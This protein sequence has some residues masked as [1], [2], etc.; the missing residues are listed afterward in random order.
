MLHT[1]ARQLVLRPLVLVVV[2]ALA[3]LPAAAGDWV[4]E[5]ENGSQLVSRYQPREST[6]DPGVV[7]LMTADGNTIGLS[8]S[9]IVS[10][11]SDIESRGF[12]T[13]IDSKTVALGWAPN[14]LPDPEAQPDSTL[15]PEMQL[16]QQ[17]VAQQNQ[18]QQNVNVDQFVDPGLA[19][20]GLP[21]FGAPTGGLPGDTGEPAPGGLGPPGVVGAPPSFGLPVPQ[22]GSLPSQGTSVPLQSGVVPGQGGSV[23]AQPAPVISP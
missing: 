22:T 13:V 5:L 15:S 9:D 12:G 17:M 3:A 10:V 2:F 21:V 6:W 1:P 23:P 7:L 20:G 8:R 11:R 19:G 14:D 18:P 4:V 16:L